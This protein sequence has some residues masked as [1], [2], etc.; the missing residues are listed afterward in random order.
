VVKL[1]LMLLEG[2]RPWN[3][4]DGDVD[5]ARERL[6]NKYINSINNPK[7][8]LRKKSTILVIMAR[9]EY[10]DLKL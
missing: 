2:T 3:Y 9:L 5:I 8:K 10:L 6:K 4:P 1:L 7:E